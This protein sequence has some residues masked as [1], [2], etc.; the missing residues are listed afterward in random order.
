MTLI[1]SG[2]SAAMRQ[3]GG[4]EHGDRRP[5]RPGRS[6]RPGAPPAAPACPSTTRPT[7]RTKVTPANPAVSATAAPVMASTSRSPRPGTRNCCM[8]DSSRN[9]S[10]T[11][12]AVGGRPARVRLPMARP[13]PLHGRRR[14]DA[15]A[16]HPGRRSRRRPH[17][18]AGGEQ[19]R[20]GQG[21]RDD[22][23]RGR[24][25]PDGQQ[26]LVAGGRADEGDAEAGQDQ[27]GVL[28]AGVGDDALQAGLHGGVGDAEHGG[29]PGQHQ[30]HAGDRGRGRAEQRQGPPQP[31]EAHVD[32]DAGH[33]GPGGPGGGGV[34]ARHP[35][36]ER[37]QADLDHE[38][39]QQ[40]HLRG[41]RAA[42]RRTCARRGQRQ[43]AGWLASSSSPASRRPR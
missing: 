14:T 11:N 19:Q 30:Q 15:R 24:Q 22:L 35:D 39:G 25:Q 1:S 33:D 23:Q 16:G 20:L 42:P 6:R 36:L 12:P 3:A 21:V 18:G 7:S 38:P 34:A 17:L 41:R 31:V 27:P 2:V 10:E 8:S 32:G 43:R 13:V 40:E 29:Q 37:H 9:H 4:A 26:A 5:G 28:H